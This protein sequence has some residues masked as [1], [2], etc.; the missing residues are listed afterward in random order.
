[1]HLSVLE[2]TIELFS[3][4]NTS[5]VSPASPRK[6][7]V[8]KHFSGAKKVCINTSLGPERCFQILPRHLRRRR[9]VL[10]CLSGAGEVLLILYI[11][12][13][14]EACEVLKKHLSDAG[15]VFIRTFPAPERP[16]KQEKYLHT[17]LFLALEPA[18]LKLDHLPPLALPV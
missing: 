9:S 3:Y 1:M 5:P 4:I 6:I 18:W 10:K 15:E 11:S 2:T 12:G 14:G 8:Y 16:E 17:P 13:A 7:R